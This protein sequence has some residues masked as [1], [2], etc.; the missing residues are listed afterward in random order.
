MLFQQNNVWNMDNWNTIQ[1]ML[2]INFYF[3]PRYT[4]NEKLMCENNFWHWL[5]Y[6]YFF[7]CQTFLVFDCMSKI[8]KKYVQRNWNLFSKNL[9]VF[10][11]FESQMMLSL[12]P[13]YHWKLFWVM[14]Q[15][16]LMFYETKTWCKS[17]F[18]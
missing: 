8:C 16:Y 2:F 11:S 7:F 6:F 10:Q 17:L 5:K 12:G 13:R 1:M 15:W 18:W 14:M 4:D 9:I 3:F